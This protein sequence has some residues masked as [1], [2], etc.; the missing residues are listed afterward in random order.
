MALAIPE[1]LAHRASRIRCDVLHGSWIGSCGRYHDGIVHGAK[2]FQSLHHLGDRGSLLA[3]SDVDANDVAALLIDDGVERDRGLAGLAVADNQLALAAADRNHGVDGFDACLQRLFH[4][5]AIYH[6]WSDGFHW[7]RLA[8][9]NGS[10]AVDGHAQRVHHA[11]DQRFAHRYGHD[12]AGAAD[13]VAFL[14]FLIFAQQHGSHLIFFQIESDACDAMRELH[15]LAGH[16]VFEAVNTCDAVAHR[17]HRSGF[18][19]TDSLFVVLN[20]A[21]Q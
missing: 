21:A 3:N 1:K 15:H 9:G 20:F 14:D 17:D 11:A 13:F 8:G 16:D 19:N 18:G 10:F 7:A 12:F 2:I 5:T 6:A 4:R